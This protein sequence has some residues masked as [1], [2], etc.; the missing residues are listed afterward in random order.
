[1]FSELQRAR[2]EVHVTQLAGL[3]KTKGMNHSLPV[4]SI[5]VL[6]SPGQTP[7]D[8]DNLVPPSM[9]FEVWSGQH[10]VAAAAQFLRGKMMEENPGVDLPV[11]A[12]LDHEQAFWY[13]DVY[14][15]SKCHP[16]LYSRY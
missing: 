16:M 12:E 9:V 8:P 13:A 4:N 5:K 14:D 6:A 1:V 7:L 11:D 15:R 3:F 10:R 2:N